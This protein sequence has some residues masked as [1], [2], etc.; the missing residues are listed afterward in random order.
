MKPQ[1]DY[2]SLTQFAKEIF[3]AELPDDPNEFFEAI[4]EGRICFKPGRGNGKSFF[5]K[6]LMEWMSTMQNEEND[7]EPENITLPAVVNYTFQELMQF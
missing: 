2:K 3:H 1:T 7:Y 6:M 4:S 5:T